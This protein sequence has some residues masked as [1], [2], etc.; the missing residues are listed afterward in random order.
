[1]NSKEAKQSERNNMIYALQQISEIL[2]IQS[3]NVSDKVET[4][5]IRSY[6]EE[7]LSVVGEYD[8]INWL[9]DMEDTEQTDE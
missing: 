8:E 5:I 6:V 3:V 2:L 4:K 1:M 7:L 9:E